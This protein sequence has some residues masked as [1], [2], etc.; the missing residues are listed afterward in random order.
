MSLCPSINHP[1][2]VTNPLES[3]NTTD[4]VVELID[5]HDREILLNRESFSRK[6]I[7]RNVY[8]DL[9]G[10][11]SR[12]LPGETGKRT[13]VE[14]GSGM[15]NVRQVIPDCI[16]TDLF[17]NEG[18]DRVED[19]YALSFEDESVDG[20]L[21]LDVFHHLR[22][23][24]TALR[25]MERCLRVGGRI[26]LLEPDM[27]LLGRLV[28]GHFHPEPL[29]LKD[30]IQ[31]HAPEAE[32]LA[33]GGP[34]YYAAQGNAKRVF[35]DGE[36]LEQIAPLR[37]RQISR[38]ASLSYV[39]SGGFSGPQL[40]PTSCYGLMRWIDRIAGLFPSLFSTRLLVVLEKIPA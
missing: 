17:P 18:I 12:W 29:G 16:T 3:T 23:P 4:G 1:E 10:T 38:I 40:Y 20:F 39:A 14:I 13:V 28:Y 36:D 24:G 21:L 15:A 34:G 7:L 35:V 33:K 25:G 8:R 11:A 19:A 6:P 37:V 26:I 31:W 27:S 2:M 32:T 30:T 9:Y 5:R 22:Y